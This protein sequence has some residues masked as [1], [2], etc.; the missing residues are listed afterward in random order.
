M[1][2]EDFIF[3]EHIL[4]SI[5][6]IELFTKEISKDSFFNNKEKQNAVVRS[7]EIM[8]EAVKNTSDNLKEKYP[9]ISWREIAG[10]RDKIIHNYFGVDLNIV[11]VIIKKDIPIL[12]KQVEKVKDDLIKTA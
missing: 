9:S 10:T 11:W 5:K 12:K 1:K 8:G 7:L 6:D 3:M 2:K 4:E